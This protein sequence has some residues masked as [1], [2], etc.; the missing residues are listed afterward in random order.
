M[1]QYV[2]LIGK[3]GKAKNK[4]NEAGRPNAWA[5]IEVRDTVAFSDKPGPWYHVR[6]GNNND[7]KSR[8]VNAKDDRDFIVELI[9]EE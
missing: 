1:P 6:P 8:W 2:K 9:K 4:I 5:I 7:D 3:T